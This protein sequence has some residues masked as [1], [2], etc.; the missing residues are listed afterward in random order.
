MMQRGTHIK[1]AL[2]EAKGHSCC[3]GAMPQAARPW[4]PN[5]RFLADLCLQDGHFV[6]NISLGAP[7]VASLRK[8]TTAFL[9]VH[10][11]V[12][13]PRQWIQVWLDELAPD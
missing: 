6:P 9:D 11:M 8:H 10:L 13:N 1:G 12:T 3:S 4:L 2:D 5:G 7:I